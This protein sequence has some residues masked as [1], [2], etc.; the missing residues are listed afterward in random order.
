[1]V[2]AKSGDPAAFWRALKPKLPDVQE[3]AIGDLAEY[4]A[5]R[6]E[7]KDACPKIKIGTLDAM[8][9]PK[10]EGGGSDS[11]ATQLADLA[12]EVCELWHDGDNEAYA[13]LTRDKHNEHPKWNE[14]CWQADQQRKQLS[15]SANL[16]TD[17]VSQPEAAALLN[18]TVSLAAGQWQREKPAYRVLSVTAKLIWAFYGIVQEV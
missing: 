7:V 10:G 12:S 3:V 9:V 4:A 14:K 17:S 1:M 18:V 15:K 13:S 11:Q 2:I 16:P 6:S 5:W 8:A